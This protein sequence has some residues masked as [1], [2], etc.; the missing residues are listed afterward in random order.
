MPTGKKNSWKIPGDTPTVPRVKAQPLNGHTGGE[1]TDDQLKN[2][3]MGINGREQARAVM[4]PSVGE[5]RDVSCHAGRIHETRNLNLKNARKQ[6]K[7]RT[8]TH[9]R[10]GKDE[11]TPSKK[12]NWDNT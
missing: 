3:G 12:K 2:V 11:N 8:Q 1:I 5:R 6:D 9:G 4:Y 7:T 10:R